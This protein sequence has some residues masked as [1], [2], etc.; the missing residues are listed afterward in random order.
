[1]HPAALPGRSDERGGDRR[2][3]AEVVVGDDQVHPGK[4]SGPQGAEEGHPTAARF[5]V[6]DIDAERL[7][8]AVGADAGGDDNRPGHHPASDPGLDVGGV[9]EDVGNSPSSGRVWNA[10]KSVS[11]S[12]Q[13]R[14]TSDLEMPPGPPSALTTSSTF[15]VDTP[16]T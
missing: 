1:V 12:A 9:R 14:D 15:F 11:S 7:R 13:I 6:A 10:S 3:E 16:W 8:G 4:P 2:F 5:A